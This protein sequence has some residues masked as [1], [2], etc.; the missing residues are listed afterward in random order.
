MRAIIIAAGQGTRLRPYTANVPKC[1]VPINGK[2]L[3]ERQID[4]FRNIGIDDI[5]VIRGYLGKAIQ[6]PNVT[7][8]DNVHF[9]Q[10]NILESLFCAKKYLVGDVIVSYGDIVYHP[11]ILLGLAKSN[12]PSALVVDIDWKKTYEN[13]TDHP[14]SEAELC[15]IVSV[16][17]DYIPGPGNHRIIELGKHVSEEEGVAEFIG[18]AKFSAASIARLQALYE[19]ALLK[20]QNHQYVFAPTIRK[21]YLTDLLNH[22]IE[23]EEWM[24]PYYIKGGWREIDTVQD[25]ERAQTEVNW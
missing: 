1:M 5:V 8:V 11:N 2:T 18:L 4:A 22:A 10:N 9:K 19:K 16:Q 20:G 13:R 25:Y 24:Y 23:E 21:A 14:S 3:L 6:Y 12:A 17:D 7:Y 15:K